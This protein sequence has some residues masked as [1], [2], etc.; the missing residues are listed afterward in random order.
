MKRKKF[1][2]LMPVAAFL[3]LL[4][5]MSSSADSRQNTIIE[6]DLPDKNALQA[7]IETGYIIDN[8]QDLTATVYVNPEELELIRNLGYVPRIVGYD[9][10]LSA[11][12]ALAQTYSYADMT[13]ELEDLAAAYPGICRL[14]SIGRSVQGRELWVLLI[15]DNPDQEEDEP[16]FKYVSTMHGNETVGTLL[17]I[18]LIN[19]I[20]SGYGMEERFTQLVD[21]TAISIMPLMN[22][23]GW[24]SVTRYNANGWDL[25]RTFPEY[26]NAFTTETIWDS[27]TLAVGS[28]VPEVRHVMD[29]TEANSFVLSANLHTGALVVNYPYD[30]DGLGIVDSPSPDDLLFEDIALGYAI[31]NTP[32]YNSLSFLNGITNGAAWYTVAD[33]MQD[34]NYR[35]VSCMEVTLE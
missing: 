19:L 27:P 7:L 34:W 21:N 13:A 35:F 8:V 5:S 16:E 31:F 18:N 30:D 29:W 3:L 14:S 33:G 24:E 28:A 20:L 17:C 9:P 22:P 23:D 10:P 4:L 26:N 15:S 6:I 11:G 2:F 12:K 1:P 25:N 32:M